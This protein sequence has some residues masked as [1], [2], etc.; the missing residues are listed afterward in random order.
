MVKV[1]KSLARKMYYSGIPITVIPCKCSLEDNDIPK[2]QLEMLC[3][4]DIDPI[5]LFNKFD[6]DIRDFENTLESSNY[7][8]YSY[9]YVSEEDM[10][11]YIMCDL[12]CN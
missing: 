5:S 8:K 6:I 1:D 2:I 12:I 3:N 9:Y 10:D 11:S 4:T 7:G